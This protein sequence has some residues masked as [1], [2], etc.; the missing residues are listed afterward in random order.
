MNES[1]SKGVEFLKAGEDCTRVAVAVGNVGI[2]D[3]MRAVEMMV[4]SRL[5]GQWIDNVPAN[6][7]CGWTQTRHRREMVMGEEK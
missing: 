3:K 4:K 6:E 5:T 1:E 7:K 2:R